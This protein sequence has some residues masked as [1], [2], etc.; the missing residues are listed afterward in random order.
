[1]S[2]TS[3]FAA[4]AP[5]GSLRS[6]CNVAT[7]TVFEELGVQL[8]GLFPGVRIAVCVNVRYRSRSYCH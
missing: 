1:M 2:I 4:V 7:P 6:L 3:P 8:S 5:E